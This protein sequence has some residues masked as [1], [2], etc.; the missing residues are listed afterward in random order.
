[1][2]VGHT[3]L[4][5]PYRPKDELSQ[6]QTPAF[7]RPILHMIITWTETYTKF[8]WYQNCKLIWPPT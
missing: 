4:S 3:T 6:H 5:E 8:I 2:S 1:M 7:R